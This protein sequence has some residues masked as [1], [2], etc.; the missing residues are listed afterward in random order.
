MK[1]ETEWEYQSNEDT[2][3]GESIANDIVV[4][5]TKRCFKYNFQ[6]KKIKV[7]LCVQDLISIFKK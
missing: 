6:A 4:I 5:Y 7:T 2:L 3:D 1:V